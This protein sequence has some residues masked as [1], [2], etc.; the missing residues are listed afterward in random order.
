[1]LSGVYPSV[2]FQGDRAYTFPY[3]KQ[4]DGQYALGSLDLLGGTSGTIPLFST[5]SPVTAA[6]GSGEDERP[7]AL[8]L[9]P[10]HRH[11]P[12]EPSRFPCPY[13]E[14]RSVR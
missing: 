12:K 6:T 9:P 10:H 14:I 3:G 2:H 7:P 1:M 13:P 4:A 8:N 11:R 5:F